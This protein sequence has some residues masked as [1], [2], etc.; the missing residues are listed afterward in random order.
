MQRKCCINDAARHKQYL[1]SAVQ[2]GHARWSCLRHCR[3]N[4]T[5]QTRGLIPMVF[6]GWQTVYEEEDPSGNQR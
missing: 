2:A 6:Q 5:S 1:P 4:K 3:Q